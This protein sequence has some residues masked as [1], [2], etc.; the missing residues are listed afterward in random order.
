M[1]IELPDDVI[2]LIYAQIRANRYGAAGQHCGSRP[3]F[4]GALW[5]DVSLHGER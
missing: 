4:E 2:G 1:R 5:H 3:R